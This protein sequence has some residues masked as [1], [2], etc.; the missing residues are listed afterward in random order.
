MHQGSVM[1]AFFITFAL[2]ISTNSYAL[3]QDNFLLEYGAVSGLNDELEYLNIGR[4]FNLYRSNF[5]TPYFKNYGEN[6][7][8]R[9]PIL[10]FGIDNKYYFGN[11]IN[12]Y[13]YTNISRV[14]NYEL[15]V[16]PFFR[17]KI[18]LGFSYLWL[19]RLELNGQAAMLNQDYDA[20]KSGNELSASILYKITSVNAVYLGWNRS[21]Y[22]NTDYNGS[23][24]FFGAKF[25]Y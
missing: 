24:A 1:R 13:F 8:G 15:G 18:G 4:E 23:E 5:I 3:R 6:I 2:L 9:E 25:L 16:S 12:P 7:S 11:E 22:S 21:V 19:G 10:D 17:G 20:A 14:Y